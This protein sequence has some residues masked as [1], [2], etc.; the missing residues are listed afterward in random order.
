LDV[1][2][3]KEKTARIHDEARPGGTPIKS[4]GWNCLGATL[5][6][7][8]DL[9]EPFGKWKRRGYKINAL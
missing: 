2:K 7:G 1:R 3:K 8:A 6:G 4:Q 5:R 9:W